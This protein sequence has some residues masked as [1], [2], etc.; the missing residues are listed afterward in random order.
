MSDRNPLR[1]FA[2]L[3]ER[4]DDRIDLTKGALLIAQ[5]EYTELDTIGQLERLDRLA[6]E[7]AADPAYPPARNI[8]ALN[9]VLFEKEKFSGNDEEYDDPRNSY[10]N[11]VLER[12]K[13]IPITLSL[14]YTEVARR[15]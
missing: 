2:R 4:A 14:V 7:E 6:T 13:G 3:V 1:E 11:Q 9:A 10:L 12:R 8:E 5:T 15:K